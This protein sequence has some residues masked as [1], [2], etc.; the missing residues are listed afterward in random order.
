MDEPIS[1]TARQ[2]LDRRRFL[3]AGAGAVAVAGCP[4]LPGDEEIGDWHDIDAVRGD[5]KGDY[6]L[7]TDL[8]EGSAGSDPL[9]ID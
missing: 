3:A 7:V 8:D 6:T 5:L 2:A 1:N 9:E 4:G